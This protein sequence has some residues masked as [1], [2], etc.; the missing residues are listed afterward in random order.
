MEDSFLNVNYNVESEII[1]VKCVCSLTLQSTGLPYTL[2]GSFA[3]AWFCS[4][5][6]WLSGKRWFIKLMLHAYIDTFHYIIFKN[7]SIWMSSSHEKNPS[8]EKMLSVQWGTW[9]PTFQ[10]LLKTSNLIISSM[11]CQFFLLK[12]TGLLC[13]QEYVYKYP[14]LNNWF[15]H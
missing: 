9:I 5:I 13:F 4:S 10:F 15:A 3:Q 6:H 12:V 7:L 11:Y 14:S 8:I 2:N 1:S